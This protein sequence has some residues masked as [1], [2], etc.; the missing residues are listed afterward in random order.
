MN[1][2]GLP[3]WEA[4]LKTCRKGFTATP[5]ASML[6]LKDCKPEAL[7]AVI[8]SVALSGRLLA[9]LGEALGLLLPEPI[10]LSKELCQYMGLHKPQSGVHKA[11]AEKAPTL[12][13]H[14]GISKHGP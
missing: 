11:K 3:G 8:E 10:E 6:H 1:C 12:K 5:L 14:L 2:T 13:L 9:D 7:H 4:Y